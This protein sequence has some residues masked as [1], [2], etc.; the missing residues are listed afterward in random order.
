MTRRR[1][2]T[3]QCYEYSGKGRGAVPLAFGPANHG[4]PSKVGRIV[5]ERLPDVDSAT[6]QVSAGPGTPVQV[7]ETTGVL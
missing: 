3:I 7:Q 6:G 2:W 1:V 4:S 5:A